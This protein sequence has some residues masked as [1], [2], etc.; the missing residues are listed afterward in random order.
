TLGDVASCD[1]ACVE[2]THRKLCTRLTDGLGSDSSNCF[3]GFYF[4]ACCQVFAV[5][6]FADAV[7]CVAGESERIYIS[8]TPLATISLAR[9]DVINS[10]ER[11]R[12]SFVSGCLT[13]S[14]E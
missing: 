7:A 6:A 11:T 3:T 9:S 8:S 2:C 10:L 12:I 5:A 14:F 4:F 13:V 1:T